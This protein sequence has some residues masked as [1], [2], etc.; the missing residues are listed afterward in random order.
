MREPSTP[1]A[2]CRTRQYHQ[3]EYS[4]EAAC[5][6]RQSTPT[7]KGVR[8]LRSHLFLG[9]GYFYVRPHM[10]CPACKHRISFLSSFRVLNPWKHRCA[11]CGAVLTGGRRA[12]VAVVAAALIGLLIAAVA[13]GMEEARRWVTLDS[14]LWFAIAV[15]LILIP[16]QYWCWKWVRL[17]ERRNAV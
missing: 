9:A 10:Y 11:S 12:T 17:E 13:I 7:P 16:Y 4:G 3:A 15:P 6:T 14:L 8:S 1:L 5:I 2:L